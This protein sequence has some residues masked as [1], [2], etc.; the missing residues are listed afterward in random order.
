MGKLK[1]RTGKVSKKSKATTIK[2]KPK[3][4]PKE[5]AKQAAIEAIEKYKAARQILNE[6]REEFSQTYP[7]AKKLLEEIHRQEDEVVSLI[8]NAKLKVRAAEETIEDFVCQIKHSK[9]TYD[10]NKVLEIA[11]TLEDP[12]EVFAGLLGAGGIKSITFNNNDAMA[13]FAKNPEF[14][15][16]FEP[17][18]KDREKLTPSVS[19]PKV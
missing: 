6:M 7:E 15:K 8:E 9:P 5:Q 13:F 1:L 19:V 2:R 11:E 14:G 16:V 4:D 3:Q 12:G 10:S 17:A 18:F